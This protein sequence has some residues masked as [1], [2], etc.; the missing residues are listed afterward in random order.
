MPPLMLDP[1]EKPGEGQKLQPG[2]RTHHP[3]E[4]PVLVLLASDPHLP[5]TAPLAPVTRYCQDQ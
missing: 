4:L 3:L 1:R 2:I 5:I